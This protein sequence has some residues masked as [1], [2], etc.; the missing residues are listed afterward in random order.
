MNLTLNA[1]D[2][3]V[4][5]MRFT[6]AILLSL[7]A[8]T[9]FAGEVTEADALAWINQIQ[10]KWTT[11]MTVGE[12]VLEGKFT[13]RK[14]KGAATGI[15]RFSDSDGSTTSNGAEIGGWQADRKVCQINGYV[16]NGDWYELKYTKLSADGGTGTITGMVAGK[17]YSNANFEI[18]VTD[19]NH[20]VWR[21][22]GKTE[23]SQPLKAS[24]EWTRET[25]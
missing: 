24:S 16:S 22:D 2:L 8:S 14:V 25:E 6:I 20:I 23:D 10:G 13:L 7:L 5:K 19:K 18:K 12:K 1:S 9:A 11:K 3:G 17:S 21:L 4:M 15:G